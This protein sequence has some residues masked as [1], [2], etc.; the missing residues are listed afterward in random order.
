MAYTS[1]V[2]ES[3]VQQWRRQQQQQWAMGKRCEHDYYSLPV[4]PVLLLP[5][6]RRSSA[7]RKHRHNNGGNIDR[8]FGTLRC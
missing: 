4:R 6:K 3:C 8:S 5:Y 2:L 7:R 1:C